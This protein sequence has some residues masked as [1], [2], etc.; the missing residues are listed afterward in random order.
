M[1]V[2]PTHVLNPTPRRWKHLD[3][4]WRRETNAKL[5][6]A[7]MYVVVP[8]IF[9]VSGRWG[10]SAKPEFYLGR[11]YLRTEESGRCEGCIRIRLDAF[12]GPCYFGR[13]RCGKAA[14]ALTIPRFGS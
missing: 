3:G 9:D 1:N 7:V 10:D 11:E 6:L 5:R 2:R 8:E 14:A 4:E 13:S 12:V